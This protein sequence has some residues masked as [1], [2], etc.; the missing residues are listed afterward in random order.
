MKKSAKVVSKLYPINF[1]VRPQTVLQT[2]MYDW[3]IFG[4]RFAGNDVG[5]RTNNP[6]S[7]ELGK[8]TFFSYSK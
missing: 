3:R 2:K 6:S 7:Q 4:I 5:L 1:F 8:L